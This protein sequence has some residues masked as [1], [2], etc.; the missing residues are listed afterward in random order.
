MKTITIKEI[1]VSVTSNEEG[2]FN[3]NDLYKQAGLPKAKEPSQWRTGVRRH[4]QVT[5]NLQALKSNSQGKGQAKE[6]LFATEKALYAYAMWVSVEFYMIVVD[7]F[8]ALVNGEIDKAIE[9]ATNKVYI[10]LAG[11]EFDRLAIDDTAYGIKAINDLSKAK[12]QYSIHASKAGQDLR[13]CRGKPAK[14]DRAEKAVIERTQ[15]K[16]SI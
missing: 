1:G 7:A 10:E 6:S 3:L 15:I 16:L 8:T 4:L 2:M 11:K 5:A 13:S 9:I 14:R 12:S